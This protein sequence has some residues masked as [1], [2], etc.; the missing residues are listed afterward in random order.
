M[1][2]RL[3]SVLRNNLVKVSARGADGVL[4][5]NQPFVGSIHASIF[6][7]RVKARGSNSCSM[8]SR[9]SFFSRALTL[10]LSAFSIS[11][12]F[13]CNVS[14]ITAAGSK[15]SCLAIV[16]NIFLL[17]ECVSDSPL[18]TGATQPMLSRCVGEQGANGF[19]KSSSCSSS[20]L[21][22]KSFSNLNR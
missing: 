9:R 20:A 3:P 10:R 11:S 12:T 18:P 22:V 2:G 13:S 14:L 8:S 19:F 16:I 7:V 4:R 5:I 1:T 21:S 15:R 6:W 17:D